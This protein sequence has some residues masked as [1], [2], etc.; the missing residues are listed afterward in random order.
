VILPTPLRLNADMQFTGKGVTI[1]FLDSGFYP[2][3]D[4][5][6]PKNRILRYV[7]A[8]G[9][10]PVEREHFNKPH[11]SSWHGLMTS[12]VAAGS[13][14]MSEGL[15]RGLAS[16]ASLVLVKTGNRR[17]RRIYDK[18]ILRALNWV[19]GNRLRYH[20]R[21]VNI[22]LGGA[23][24]TDG[25]PGELDE[26]V[27]EAVARG[28]VVVTA[29]GNDGSPRVIPP[30]S[31]VSAITVGG[32]D[33]QNTLDARGHRMYG[34]NFGHGVNHLAKPEI[35][36]PAIWLAAPM[37]PGTRVHNEAL[38]LWRL[39]R[40]SDEELGTIL[41]TEYAQSRFKKET[42]RQ[43]LAEIRAAIRRRMAE[44]K[45][46]HPHYQHV[47]GTSFAASIVSSV[48]AQMIE[49]NPLLS[50]A[51]VKQLLVETARPLENAPRERQGFGVVDA[52]GAVAAA[53]RDRSIFQSLPH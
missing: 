37:L 31:A 49:A 30:A 52:A 45:Y 3:P 5:V 15:Y 6:R 26:L 20:I 23:H 28:I 50:P 1:A 19:I 27:E 38:F 8:T 51:R 13:G 32:L 35:I 34:S 16:Q 24:P 44:N 17:G 7:D 21:V 2:H 9:P 43:P 40:A 47:D 46:I 53:R 41:Q 11:V 42:L 10:A 36:A 14:F 39:E 33:D 48:V 22:S 29:V 18:D 12:S 4:L 25:Q